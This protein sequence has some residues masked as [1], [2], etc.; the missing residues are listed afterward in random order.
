MHTK[1]ANIHELS[2]LLSVKNNVDDDIMTY[3]VHF[4]LG[5]LLHRL[6][7]EKQSGISAIQLVLSLC[8]FR[9]NRESIHSIYR[10]NFYELLDTGKN[11]YYRMMSRSS[12]DWR[13]LLLGMGKRFESIVR[14]EKAEAEHTA[15]CFI[16]DDTIL[17]KLGMA[18]ERISM[19]F[20]HVAGR[21]VLG[22]KLLL[23][24]YFDGKSTLPIDFSIH[25]E[26]GRKGNYGLKASDRRKQFGKRRDKNAPDYGRL[27]ESDMEKPAVA[28]EMLRRAWKYGYRA[29]Y[30]L[31]DSW[32]TS[33]KLIAS[34]RSIGN[35]A[36]HLAGL[37]K[38]GNTKYQVM[39]RRHNALELA[40]LYERSEFFHECRKYKCHYIL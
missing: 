22:Y 13:S 38:M 35:G 40:A 34:V 11:C 37:A 15:S 25:R 21:C 4:G 30:V 18:M 7:M 12:M 16:I 2:K 36:M 24:A 3:F 23:L 6:S 10:K 9:I 29:K 26:K 14:R 31:C 1:I 27:Q 20:D 17:E 39:D 28:I 5:H 19:V 8:L 32:F 33:E